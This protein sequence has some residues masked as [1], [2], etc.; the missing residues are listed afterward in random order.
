MGEYLRNEASGADV[1]HRACFRPCS[2]SSSCSRCRC[3]CICAFVDCFRCAV[4]RPSGLSRPFRPAIN[5]LPQCF[6]PPSPS[7]SLRLRGRVAHSSRPA[8][9]AKRRREGAPMR[10]DRT[11]GQQNMCGPVG[12]GSPRRPRLRHSSST[13]APNTRNSRL[14]WQHSSNMITALSMR[15][16]RLLAPIRPSKLAFQAR[17]DA[18]R[19]CATGGW[20]ARLPLG[21]RTAPLEA[22]LRS[23]AKEIFAQPSS[24]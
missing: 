13:S 11:R 4:L 9:I 22:R 24:G 3:C 23:S 12:I 18:D 19:R 8:P 14:V 2:C 10:S 1:G 17:A 7:P 21:A 16:P 15:T 6:S 5:C 20:A